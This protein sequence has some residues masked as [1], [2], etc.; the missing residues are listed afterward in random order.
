MIWGL[1]VTFPGHNSRLIN[2]RP[3]HYAPQVLNFRWRWSSFWRW[4]FH[5]DGDGDVTEVLY[6]WQ[7]VGCDVYHM[8]DLCSS[9]KKST[10]WST[11]ASS[12]ATTLEAQC[13]FVS[14]TF[15]RVRLE[16]IKYR[17]VSII[18]EA[19]RRRKIFVR[20]AYL[21]YPRYSAQLRIY[22]KIISLNRKL[23]LVQIWTK[24]S[25]LL[26]KNV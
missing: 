21:G 2:W 20:F 17:E 6:W 10:L 11:S 7:G 26:F 5:S 25:N 4:Y 18:F 13:F 24:G 19:V 23:S 16:T 1:M 9:Y 8:Q 22:D 15:S 3:H 14:S 12:G